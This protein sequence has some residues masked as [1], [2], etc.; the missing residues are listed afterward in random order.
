M[1]L[2]CNNKK[3]RF[4]K[5]WSAQRCPNLTHS[6]AC[7]YYTHVRVD[8]ICYIKKTFFLEGSLCNVGM[9]VRKRDKRTTKCSNS[10]RPRQTTASPWEVEEILST[11]LVCSHQGCVLGVS[12]CKFGGKIV[13]LFTLYAVPMYIIL[14]IFIKQ[15][16]IY[17]YSMS[18]LAH[19]MTSHAFRSDWPSLCLSSSYVALSI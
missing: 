9:W 6:M 17:T 19:Y 13:H 11:S 15:N 18:K 3:G 14:Y 12:C 10:Q 2:S 8:S 5:Y 16:I 7:I 1:L 4:P